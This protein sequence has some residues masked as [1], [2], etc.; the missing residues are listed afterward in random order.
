MKAFVRFSK[1][2]HCNNAITMALVCSMLMFQPGCG[3]PKLRPPMPG[4][5]IPETFNGSDDPENSSQLP[6]GEFFNDP[7]LL[8]L[9][10]QALWG[11]QELRIL[12][13]DIA[14]ANN[15]V[16]RRPVRTFPLSRSGPTRANKLGT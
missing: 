15:E 4:P 10:D 12:A 3:I 1:S 16:R 11:N 6:I 9:I 7:Q 8:N 5:A 14:I 13:Q 2:N